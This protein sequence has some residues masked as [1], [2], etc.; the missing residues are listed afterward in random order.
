MVPVFLPLFFSSFFFRR[1][2]FPFKQVEPPGAA[3]FFSPWIPADPKTSGTRTRRL[4]ESSGLISKS[5]ALMRLKPELIDQLLHPTLD[6][7]AVCPNTV[8][9]HAA[10]RLVAV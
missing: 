5:Q 4:R 10:F 3:V 9:Q 6:P 1:W 2:C 8:G 7:Q